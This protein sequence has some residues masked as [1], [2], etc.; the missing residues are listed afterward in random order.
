MFPAKPAA[1]LLGLA[2]LVTPA[3]GSDDGRYDNSPLKSWFE[4]LESEFG[5]CCTDRDGY[6]V[7]DADWESNR[8]RYRVYMDN[9]WVDV[10]EGAVVTQ[11]N[12]FGRTMVWRHYIDGHPRVRCFMPGSMI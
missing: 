8:G 1:Q 11:P 12:R 10:P 7:S 6:I 3:L 5:K 2:V 4:S 9:E